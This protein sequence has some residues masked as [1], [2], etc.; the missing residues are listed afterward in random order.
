MNCYEHILEIMGN[1][2]IDNNDVVRAISE[3][4]PRVIEGRTRD[5]QGVELSYN[6]V[7]TPWLHI[8]PD[9]QVI[10]PASNRV[11]T[12]VVAGVRMKIDF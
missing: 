7:I 9:L 5:E 10:E 3:K 1:C 11:D 8:I 2:D 6:I 4:L 12:A